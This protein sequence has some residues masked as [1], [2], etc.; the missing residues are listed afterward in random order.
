MQSF[1]GDPSLQ[2]LPFETYFP[3]AG[4]PTTH[5]DAIAPAVTPETIKRLQAHA[6]EYHLEFVPP[7]EQ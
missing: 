1:Y 2:P 3:K 6:A 5:E 4:T 7:S